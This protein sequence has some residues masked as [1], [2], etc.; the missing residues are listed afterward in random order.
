MIKKILSFSALFL[1]MLSPSAL[2]SSVAEQD[3]Y[4]PT[5]VW[6]VMIVQLIVIIVLVSYITVKNNEDR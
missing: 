6:A 4:I 5:W 1:A 3:A 2:A